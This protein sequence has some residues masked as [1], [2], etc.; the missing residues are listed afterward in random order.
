MLSGSDARPR[1]LVFVGVDE[2]RW[3]INTS[4]FSK[5]SSPMFILEKLES[6]SIVGG[7]GR[8]LRDLDQLLP[9]EETGN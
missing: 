7:P 1:R 5:G 6:K 8:D 3:C 2:L 4:V 9:I